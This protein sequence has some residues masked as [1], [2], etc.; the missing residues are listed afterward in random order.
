MKS[1]VISLLQTVFNV[2]C[3]G[4][5]RV[6]FRYLW[7]QQYEDVNLKFSLY[8]VTIHNEELTEQTGTERCLASVTQ[9]MSQLIK[10][11]ADVANNS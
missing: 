8:L 6:A 11:L 3:S 4:V 7:M 1:A 10:A 2:D 5:A 9:G